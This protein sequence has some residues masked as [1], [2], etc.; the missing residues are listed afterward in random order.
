MDDSDSH[1][2]AEEVPISRESI[3]QVTSSSNPGTIWRASSL[4]KQSNTVTHDRK[5]I[6]QKDTINRRENNVMNSSYSRDEANWQSSED[7]ILRRQPSGVFEREPEPRKLPAPEDLL[8]HYKDPQGEIQGPFSGIDI[9]GWFE[10]GYFGIDLE[11]RLASAPKD[12]PF[13]LLGDVMP[14]LRAKA[15]PPPGF[16]VPKQGEPSDLSSRPNFSNFEKVHAGASEIDMIRNEPRP[17][18][19]A[20][21]RFLE[22]L[23]S[24]SMSNPSQGLGFYIET[25][26]LIYLI[27]VYNF[28]C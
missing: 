28:G 25:H 23:M 7:P 15:R 5:E 3:I 26:T 17:T 12:S 20:E 10:S 22:S 18:A 13:S 14:H 4:G 24:G 11:V 16:G 6:P 27:I 21:N 19:E 2:R 8:L 1:R 9:I